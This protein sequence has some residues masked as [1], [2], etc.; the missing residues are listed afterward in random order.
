MTEKQAESSLAPRDKLEGEGCPVPPAP[1]EATL[2]PLRSPDQ[3]GRHGEGG[4]RAWPG[5]TR[6]GK[7]LTR[8]RTKTD[9]MQQESIEVGRLAAP[10]PAARG[11]C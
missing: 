5:D 1:P 4:A 6:E 11:P 7:T 9:D 3:V 8:S 2:T 10:S